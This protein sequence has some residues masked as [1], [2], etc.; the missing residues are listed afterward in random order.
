MCKFDNERNANID[1]TPLR[2][3]SVT[4]DIE[5]ESEQNNLAE[6]FAKE[7]NRGGS[8]IRMLPFS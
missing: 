7:T 6:Q 4:C 2:V 5:H 8:N 1:G 3:R